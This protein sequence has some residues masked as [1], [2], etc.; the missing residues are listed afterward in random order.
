MPTPRP[1][2]PVRG[3]RTGRPIMA[4]FD[5]LGRRG[6]LRV[7]WELREARLTF[8]A[9]AA[10]SG[11]SPSVLNTRLAELREALVVETTDEGYGLTNEGRA[12]LEVLA[13][14]SAWAERWATVTVKRPGATSR[15]GARARG[16]G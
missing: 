3:S 15:A 5:L 12:L 2:R 16:R 9:L 6:A 11:S 10:A 13:P 14:L 4:V 1:G 7:L 8:R